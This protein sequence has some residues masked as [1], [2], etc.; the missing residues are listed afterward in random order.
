MKLLKKYTA[1]IFILNSF[2]NAQAINSE[3]GEGFWTQ[4]N[5]IRL[6]NITW[7]NDTL[8]ASRNPLY[9]SNGGIYR[10]VDGGLNWDTLYSVSDVLSSGLRLFIHPTNHKILYMIYGA[11][12]RSTNA[13]LTWQII[14][15]SFGPLV[16]LGI[17]SNNPNIM[18]VTKS[19]PYGAVFKTT[20]AGLTWNDASIGLPSEE[21]FQ[22][23]PIEV[24]PDCPDTL[25]LGT[26]TGLYRSTNG[27]VN[28][29]STTVEGF[30]PG[31]NFHPHLPN[32][33]FAGTTYDWATYK[34]TDFGGTWYKTIGSFG[35]TKY[36]FNLLD[37]SLI[38]NSENLK[39]TNYGET[40][41]K[42]DTIYSGWGDLA[43]NNLKNPTIYGLNITYGLFE[44]TDIISSVEKNVRITNI[45]ESS[46]FPNPFNNTTSIQCELKRNSFLTIYIYNALG[47]KIK[48]LVNQNEFSAGR[49]TYLWNGQDDY[50]SNVASGFYLCL[51][52]IENNEQKDVQTLKLLLLK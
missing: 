16:R 39:S 13:G 38:Y 42:L 51:I 50:Q 27:G 5:T 6:N 33:A 11:L 3:R 10:S 31:L 9:Q 34:S 26:N 46:C 37:D 4:V 12:Y 41:N 21:Y 2:L 32:I 48:T 7:L 14:F 20:D 40:W 49:H 47:Q 23:G 15:A 22:A 8:Y 35:S 28:W 30:I 18:Y 1:L 43:I 52:F 24:N 29:D 36:L 44:Y 25:L 45:P 17:N 19:I